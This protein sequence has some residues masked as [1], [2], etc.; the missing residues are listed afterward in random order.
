MRALIS[1]VFILLA[2]CGG[3]SLTFYDETGRKVELKSDEPLL[4]YV[5]SGSCVGHAEDLKKLSRLYPELSKRYRVYAVALFMT[6]EDALAYL[7]KEKIRLSVPLLADPKGL[8]E[9]RYD[10]VFLPATLVI[11]DG[12]LVAVTPR[13]YEPKSR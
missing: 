5:W 7:K 4:L 11:K 8:L 1:F 10:L 9:E 6:P 3:S 13:L 2:A 12:K